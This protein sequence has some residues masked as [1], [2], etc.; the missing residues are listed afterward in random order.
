[1]HS[2]DGESIAAGFSET[3]V[4]KPGSHKTVE[5]QLHNPGFAPGGY[6]FTLGIFRGRRE[7]LDV[8]QEVLHFEV[9]NECLPEGISEWNPGWGHIGLNIETRIGNSHLSEIHFSSTK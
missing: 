8:V 1:L 2:A 5:L 6:C 4:A 3:L 7:M 9:G